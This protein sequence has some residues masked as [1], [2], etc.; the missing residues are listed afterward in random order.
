MAKCLVERGSKLLTIPNVAGF[1][2]VTRA[3]DMGNEE[4]AC[5]L[6]L[7]TLLEELKPEKGYHAATL[8]NLFHYAQMLC[9]IF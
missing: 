6:Y 5:Y 7:V 8:L 2:L 9:K 3:P 1:I 4:M